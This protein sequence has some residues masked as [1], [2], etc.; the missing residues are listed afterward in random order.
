M[1]GCDL[2]AVF[3]G[4]S[5]SGVVRYTVEA[6][7]RRIQVELERRG[8]AILQTPH[9]LVALLTRCF[10]E[11]D[12]DLA[13][14]ALKVRDSGSTATVAL[15]TPSHVI[16]A[17]CGDSPAILI[18]PF[19]GMIQHEA[20]KHEPTLLK[21]AERIRAAG[22]TVE[23]DEYGTPRVDG[24][25]MVSRAFGDFSLKFPDLAAPPFE[26][27]WAR[28]K[29][30]AEPDVV[31]WPR[32]LLGVLA[33]MS[34]GFVETNTNALKPLAQ[35]GKDIQVALKD[36]AFNLNAAT[37]LLATRHMEAAARSSPGPYDGDDL[38]MIL[39]DVGLQESNETTKNLVGGGGS[40]AVALAAASSATRP[41]TR[42][43][44]AGRRNRT[45]KKSRLAK[46][47]CVPAA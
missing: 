45:G 18:N 27:D 10:L 43:A 7:P 35:V 29:V 3:D 19:S 39:V 25:L 4:H 30:T 40:A 8:Q 15:V 34:D 6:L 13:R 23:I 14:N 26:A 42:K 21:E 31:I 12:K 1:D 44:R 32:P 46:I 33:I 9:E 2:F 38:S 47:F 16:L 22:G 24:S 17:Y 11:H 37:A 41:K 36:S 5:G 20:G 28:F